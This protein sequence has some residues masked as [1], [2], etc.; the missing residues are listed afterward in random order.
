MF[1]RL[2]TSAAARAHSSRT[3]AAA[4]CV[5]GFASMR[6]L[7][8]GRVCCG[9]PD[10]VAPAPTY[11]N[12]LIKEGRRGNSAHKQFLERRAKEVV[13]DN[14][15]VLVFHVNNVKADEWTDLRSG[16][17]AVLRGTPMKNLGMLFASTTC[18]VHSK[19]L[20][21]LQKMLKLKLPKLEL[22][23]G[24]VEDRLCSRDEIIALGELPTL[25]ISRA[26]LLGLLSSPAQKLVGMLQQSP[27]DLVA[28]LTRHA[29]KDNVAAAD[30]EGGGDNE[31]K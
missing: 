12:A 20:D 13:F 31:A 3:A 19:E 4:A 24:K 28:A 14:S 9:E 6:S 15:V 26:Q 17:A 21:S 7:T 25:D 29:E 10:V 18:V 30:G 1:A 5:G 11:L 23:G 8:A 27:S 22:L 2:T 16:F